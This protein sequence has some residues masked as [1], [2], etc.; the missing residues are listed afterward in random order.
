M[1]KFAIAN[2]KNRINAKADV[3]QLSGDDRAVFCFIAFE[4]TGFETL[5]R[6]F[7]EMGIERLALAM[8]RLMDRELIFQMYSSTIYYAVAV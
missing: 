4:S 3:E 2:L 5:R 8:K 7:H 1:N 6:Q